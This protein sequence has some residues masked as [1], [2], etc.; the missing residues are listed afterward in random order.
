M[1]EPGRVAYKF[2]MSRQHRGR[3]GDPSDEPFSLDGGETLGSRVVRLQHLMFEELYRLFRLEVS[4]PRLQ[5]VVPTSLE[6]SPDL[7][8][9]KVMFAMRKPPEES[10][11]ARAQKTPGEKRQVVEAQL[12][13]VM[14]SLQKVTPFLRVR[15]ADG[16]MMKRLPD[17]HFHRDRLAEASLRAADV[18]TKERMKAAQKAPVSDE[19]E[20]P[21][22]AEAHS[23]P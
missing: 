12:K 1:A 17:L 7:R 6:L 4:D 23:E 11:A 13:L 3:K 9:A 16:V 5:D 14:Q 10:K 8:N 21:D 2:G 18:M 19:A 22:D 15:L 20:A